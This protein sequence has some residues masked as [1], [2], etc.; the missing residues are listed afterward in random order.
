MYIC[1]NLYTYIFFM[2]CDERV[3]APSFLEPILWAKSVVQISLH[4]VS[5]ALVL[6]AAKSLM[7]NF[8]DLLV[9]SHQTGYRKSPCFVG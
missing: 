1:I 5:A 7:S 4:I 9:T 3:K 8:P 6:F 2:R